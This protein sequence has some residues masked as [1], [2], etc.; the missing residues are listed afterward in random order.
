MGRSI[1]FGFYNGLG[2]FISDSFIMK[3]FHEKNYKITIMANSWLYEIINFI[4]PKANIVSYKSSLNLSS[5]Q[6]DDDYIFLSPTYLHPITLE[7]RA[8][9]LYIFKYL[10][11]KKNTK[12]S[13]KII[14]PKFRRIT[15]L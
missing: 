7:Y 9:P 5:F 12:H 8:V 1:T 11:V 4:F 2:D 15:N 13:T 10:I 14:R 3:Y 6:Y